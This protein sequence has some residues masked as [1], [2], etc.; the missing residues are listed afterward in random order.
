MAFLKN[1]MSR[2]ISKNCVFLAI[3]TAATLFLNSCSSLSNNNSDSPSW[4][5]KPKANNYQNLYGVAGGHDIENATKRALVNAA[6]R[7]FVTISSK[8]SLTSQENNYDSLEEV[9]ETISQNIEKISFSD[10]ELSNSTQRGAQFFAEVTINRYNF[11]SQQKD[12]LRFLERKIANLDKNSK[13]KNQINRRNALIKIL[14]LSKELEINSRIL[15]GAG[16]DINISNKLNKIANFQNELN[17][18]S[19]KI[20]FYFSMNSP[21]EISRV[22]KNKINKEQIKVSRQRNSSNKNQ[23]LVKIKSKKISKK[24]YGAFITKVKISFENII[25]GK[26]IA[27]NSIEVSG[28]STIGKRESYSAAIKSLEEKLAQDNSLKILGISN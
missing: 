11:I 20:E 3:F 8:S 28:S 16:E 5:I 12:R 19:D 10:Y 27:S 22:I 25:S 2:K 14:D 21:R 6:S 13:G 7:L 15:K 26:I 4:Y 18:S 17:Q 1:L 23:I 9:S 24:I